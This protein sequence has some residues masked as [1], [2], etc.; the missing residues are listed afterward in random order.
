MKN[1]TVQVRI[2]D[3]EFKI[4][5]G[6]CKKAGMSQSDYLRSCISGVE[7]KSMENKREIMNEV[8]KMFTVLN[9]MVN[10]PEKDKLVKGVNQI[11]RFLK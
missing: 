10:T 2:T 5:Q 3:E 7:V 4:L 9:Q 1:K 11:C 8:C 6:N